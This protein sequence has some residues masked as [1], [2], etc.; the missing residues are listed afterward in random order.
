M[1][2]DLD[3]S[4]HQP[5]IVPNIAAQPSVGEI[6]TSLGTNN[7]YSIGERIGEGNFGVVYKCTDFWSNDLAAKVLK[8]PTDKSRMEIES[9]ASAE[10]ARLLALRH[11]YITY[12]FDAFEYQDAFYVI[13]ER[14]YCPLSDLFR[15]LDDFDGQLWLMPIAR[16][17][18]QAVH[19]LHLNQ[20]A[21]QDIHPGNIFAA[22]AKDEMI[23][24]APG[25]L[26]F[27]LADLGVTKL[28][29]EL[30]ATNTL[31]EWIRPPE[32]IDPDQFG[33]L[34]N[35]IDIYHLGLLFLQLA[36]SRELQF[37]REEILTGRPR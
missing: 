22:F 13:T 20:Y 9:A 25:T 18:L 37:S 30:D 1:S 24:E 5:L 12:V 32:A 7:T 26:R 3:L 23:P 14:C 8:Q 11:P 27:K 6:I 31:A 36:Y 29:S 17:I 34:S 33:P 10:F 21:H 2:G 28:F 15:S 16:C 19:Y 35:R 4:L